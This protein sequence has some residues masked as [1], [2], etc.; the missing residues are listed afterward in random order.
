M[1]VMRRASKITESK[2]KK[3]LVRVRDLVKD[4]M[5]PHKAQKLKEEAREKGQCFEHPSFPQD[6]EEEQFY[7]VTEVSV[8]EYNRVE[9]SISV[10]GK[11]E[12]EGEALEDMVGANGL[13]GAG[14]RAAV[15]ML[16]EKNSAA[17][18]QD[19]SNMLANDKV[20]KI[21]LGRQKKEPPAP[22]SGP[23]PEEVLSTR[24]IAISTQNDILKEI[25]EARGFG[26]IIFAFGICFNSHLSDHP[27]STNAQSLPHHVPFRLQIIITRSTFIFQVS[28]FSK[29]LMV[30]IIKMEISAYKQQRC[31]SCFLSV[32]NTSRHD[33]LH[34]DHMK[35]R[36]ETSNSLDC[37][38]TLYW[39]CTKDKPIHD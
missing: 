27:R 4:G 15:P 17:F 35:V 11:T 1:A 18:H 12:L 19:L 31:H 7:Y 37:L 30:G 24:D 9:E 5:A 13:L 38:L 22:A 28:K 36:C 8:T 3:Q 2:G 33:C 32:P 25:K 6:E 20:G 14:V 26:E 23:P 39:H 21:K 10:S 29:V 34:F 16:A